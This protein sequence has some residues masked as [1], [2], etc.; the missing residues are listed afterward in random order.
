M[1]QQT[2]NTL[3]VVFAVAALTPI[4][5]D[6]LR[7]W[8]VVPAVVLEILL[9]I[10]VG[11]QVLGL[12][13]DDTIITFVADVGLALLMFL[14]G[15]EI[16][17]ARIR[18]APMKL[19]GMGWLAS[20]VLGLACGFLVHGFTFASLVVGL[21]LTTTALSTL[22]P[23]LRDAG[24]LPT[25]FGVRI[26]AIGAF[27]EFGPIIA[28][29]LLLSG[30]A[31]AQTA[32]VLLAF[33]V[34]TIVVVVIALRQDSGRM[35]KLV[36]TTLGTSVQYAVRI[37]MFIVVAMLWVANELRLDLLLGA[38]VAGIVF[39]LVLRRS[40]HDETELVHGKLETI[41]FGVF[42]PF[43]FVVSGI[44]FDLRALLAHPVSLALVPGFVVLFLL[45]RGGPL[46]MLHRHDMPRRERGDLAL[47]AST[48]LPLL[49]VIATIGTET[50]TLPTHTAAA[51]V[52]AG[53]VTVL[54]FPLVALRG[55]RAVD[56]LEPGDRQPGGNGARH[57]RSDQRDG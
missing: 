54:V 44:R 11:P 8:V 38:F 41:A 6:L 25:A 15:Y 14:A 50:H 22:L 30:Q 40:G 55:R 48:A 53:L 9:G 3:A 12:A 29:A 13:H 49:V 43:F 32:I 46:L 51:L 57:E 10:V 1:P 33:A 34:I 39:R 37:A 28:I 24:L 20:L 42:V 18:G 19:A 4:G 23:I 36:T 31:P 35:R 27:G 17:F 47:L 45:V 21:A 16:D 56:E 7:R 52:G 2:M 26:L 5:V